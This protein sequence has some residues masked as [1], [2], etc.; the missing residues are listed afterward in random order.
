MVG[1]TKY[2]LSIQVVQ[3][4]HEKRTLWDTKIQLLLIKFDGGLLMF[5]RCSLSDK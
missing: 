4:R 5:T 1:A 3:I 2:R